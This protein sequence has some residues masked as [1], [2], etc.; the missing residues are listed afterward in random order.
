MAVFTQNNVQGSE[1]PKTTLSGVEPV[2]TFAF[3]SVV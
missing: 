1:L 2:R 3:Q